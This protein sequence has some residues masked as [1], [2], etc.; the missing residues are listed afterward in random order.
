[1]GEY[2]YGATGDDWDKGWWLWSERRILCRRI[3]V[4]QVYCTLLSL[5]RKAGGTSRVA[6]LAAGTVGF[7]RPCGKSGACLCGTQRRRFVGLTWCFRR[8]SP[9]QCLASAA[10]P[11]AVAQQARVGQR[12]EQQALHLWWLALR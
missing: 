7:A 4:A 11:A 1:M 12:R 8:A 10:L 3:R 2:R 5:K 6:G 9:A